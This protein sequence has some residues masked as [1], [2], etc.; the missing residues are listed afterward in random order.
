MKSHISATLT[1]SKRQDVSMT[2]HK[3]R[4]CK[5]YASEIDWR[6]DSKLVRAKQGNSRVFDESH[7]MSAYKQQGEAIKI[8]WAGDSNSG[9]F[10]AQATSCRCCLYFE[11]LP[12]ETSAPETP[13]SASRIIDNLQRAFERCAAHPLHASGITKCKNT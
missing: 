13:Q 11:K 6:G 2:T 12:S 4:R 8:G 9:G 3:T 5:P 10:F 1:L 7:A